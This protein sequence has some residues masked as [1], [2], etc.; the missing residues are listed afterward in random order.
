M[1]RH[2]TDDTA[3]GLLRAVVEYPLDL[4]VRL[5]LA[6]RLDEIGE[7][8]RASLIR[9]QQEIP[10]ATIGHPFTAEET[11]LFL[12]VFGDQPAA[13]GLTLTLNR[14]WFDDPEHMGDVPSDTPV[15]LVRNGFVEEVRCPLDWWLGGQCQ[16]YKGTGSEDSALYHGTCRDCHGIGRT[17]AHGP[18]VVA[19]H[20]VTVVIV[21]DLE[22]GP[23]GDYWEW[24][25]VGSDNLSLAPR[26][27]FR[28]IK[29]KQAK[30]SGINLLLFESIRS[31]RIALSGALVDL[32]RERAGLPPITW[33]VTP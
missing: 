17:P 7:G 29:K 31:A 19:R 5:I 16:A 12:A 24:H 18:E 14:E 6:D 28:R 27:V 30:L 33:E 8:E 20:P 25:Q 2:H 23:H 26:E 22:P 13:D 11:E 4:T 15:V 9:I 10:D 21:T 3:Y 1:T 32:A